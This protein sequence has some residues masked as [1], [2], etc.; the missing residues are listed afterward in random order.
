[1]SSTFFVDY[2]NQCQNFAKCVLD[3]SSI[4]VFLFVQCGTK[5]AVE[6]LFTDARCV[7]VVEAL[8]DGPEAADIALAFHAL[9]KI[10]DDRYCSGEYFIV[11]GSEKGY[12]ET[13]ARLNIEL[14]KRHHRTEITVIDGQVT[15]NLCDV[16]PKQSCGFCKK[17]F[18]NEN[19]ATRHK[20]G[21]YCSAAPL[22]CQHCDTVFKCSAEQDSLKDNHTGTWYYQACRDVGCRKAGCKPLLDNCKHPICDCGCKKRFK[23]VKAVQ[24][25][26]NLFASRPYPCPDCG[27]RFE[28][29]KLC[30]DHQIDD[31]P[32]KHRCLKC[33]IIC[34]NLKKHNKTCR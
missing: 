5:T 10:S 11:K 34:L 26:K 27:L 4:E 30:S 2:E 28:S 3:S 20:S 32:D 23:D 1:M 21:P 9:Q 24:E 22:K 17:L 16:F 15:K 18:R 31:H 33:S 7:T 6:A 13:I 25:H 8:T 14:K 12:G 29:K 19:D